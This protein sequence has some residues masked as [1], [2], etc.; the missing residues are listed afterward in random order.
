MVTGC[1]EG[2]NMVDD[3]IIDD[4]KTSLDPVLTINTATSEGDGSVMVSGTSANLPAETTVTITLDGTVTA[5]TAIDEQGT[6][7]TTVPAKKVAQL[8]AGTVT[9]TATAVGAEVTS[10][11]EYAP[12]ELEHEVPEPVPPDPIEP[13]ENDFVGQVVEPFL[14]EGHLSDHARAVQGVTLTVISGERAG[15]QS[16][17]DEQGNYRFSDPAGETLQLHLRTEK[18]GYEPKEVIVHRNERT[19]T[20]AD[21]VAFNRDRLD[22]QKN[23]GTI[24][25]GHEWP[26]EVRFI[27][28]KTLLPHDLLLI[29]TDELGEN[30]SGLYAGQVGMVMVV[31]SDCLFKTI[32]H[33]LGH[34]HQHAIA[35]KEMGSDA[36]VFDWEETAEGKAYL[37]A[38]QKDWEGVGKISYDGG[39]FL[40]SFENMAQ[41]ANHFWNIE[42]KFDTPLCFNTLNLEKEAPNRFRW[43]QEW[44]N[45]KYD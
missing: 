41:T 15:E 19:T 44:L 21:G 14:S 11:F 8:T 30:Y 23:P 26:D 40:T 42:G 39:H 2:M 13:H 17:T 22:P 45:K 35:V 1:D 10:S 31:N 43:A 32:A 33:E 37:T 9:V 20:L 24:F 27:L 28:E 36:N 29:R 34:A 6:W 38:Q 16:I 25:M 4:P 5:A 18:E 3:P 12:P 7:L